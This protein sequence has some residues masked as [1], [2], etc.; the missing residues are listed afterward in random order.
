MAKEDQAEAP[1]AAFYEWTI[2]IRVAPCWVADGFDLTADRAHTM[3]W[4]DLGYA[5]GSEIEAEIVAAPDPDRVAR[6]MGYKS[7]AEREER[8][9]GG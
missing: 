6:E 4:R 8:K 3:V 2:K 7:A 5:H 9:G 1:E